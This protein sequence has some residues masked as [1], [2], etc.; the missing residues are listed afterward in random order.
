MRPGE[1]IGLRR[2]ALDVKAAKLS[3]LISRSYE[4]DNAPKTA[5]S[6][7]TIRLRPD[8]VRVLR[9]L[10]RPVVPR[11]DDFVFTTPHGHP[12]DLDRF[13]EQHWHRALSATGICPRTFYATRHTFI[14]AAV[15]R[16]ANLKW[17]ADY[18]GT[19]VEMIEKH[20][21]GPLS[22]AE[23]DAQLD[24]LSER[25]GDAQPRADRTSD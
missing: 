5:R 22:D 21:A 24:L 9:S 3:V 15:K 20:Y 14:T 17:I 12:V 23:E 19:S 8:V 18:C 7:R 10:P 11:P 6:R 4:E 13:V 16:G 25:G 2:H 1:G